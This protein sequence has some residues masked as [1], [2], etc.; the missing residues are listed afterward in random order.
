[1]KFAFLNQLHYLSKTGNRR[2]E[3][4]RLYLEH[5]DPWNY[6]DSLYEQDKYQRTLSCALNWR[7]RGEAALEVGCSIGVFSRLLA[8][9]FDNM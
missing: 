2:F 7:K 9:H 5:G 6:R 1:L 8:A 4:E 3:F